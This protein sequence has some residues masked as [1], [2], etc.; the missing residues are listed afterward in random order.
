MSERKNRKRHG[1]EQIIVR[2]RGA[3]S[4]LAGRASVVQGRFSTEQTCLVSCAVF[5]PSKT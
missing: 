4:R 2:L 3:E 5:Q 1:P